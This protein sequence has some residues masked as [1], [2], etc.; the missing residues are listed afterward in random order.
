[1]MFEDG[2]AAHASWQFRLYNIRARD[3]LSWQS[4]VGQLQDATPRESSVKQD[5][6]QDGVGLWGSINVILALWDSTET[7][8]DNW[9]FRR[10]SRTD[11]NLRLTLS[12]RGLLGVFYVNYL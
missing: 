5:S 8:V 7:C 6:M 2:C 3:C 9:T 10:R 12:A 4:L 11:H 1:M